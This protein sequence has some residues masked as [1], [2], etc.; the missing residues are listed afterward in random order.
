MLQKVSIVPAPKALPPMAVGVNHRTAHIHHGR[1]RAHHG[2]TFRQYSDDAR[3]ERL[4]PY[5]IDKVG[6][7]HYRLT[8]KWDIGLAVGDEIESCDH[9]TFRSLGGRFRAV[10][11]APCTRAE[12]KDRSTLE[13][14]TPQPPQPDLIYEIVLQQDL[15]LKVGDAVTS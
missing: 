12:G 1:A 14:R 15:P 2:T 7:Q 10:Q 4:L 5:V 13:G 3:N 9:Q 6:P 11:Q 8:P